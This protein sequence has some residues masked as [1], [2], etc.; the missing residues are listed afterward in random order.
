M[1]QEQ[2][3]A[4]DIT[5]KCSR[6]NLQEGTKN[7]P[8]V[9]LT[10]IL[11]FEPPESWTNLPSGRECLHPN[12]CFPGFRGR[13]RRFWCWT[14]AWMTPGCLESFLSFL[15]E[16]TCSCRTYWEQGGIE[17]DNETVQNN[18]VWQFS[19]RSSERSHSCL[20]SSLQVCNV[21][22]CK[23]NQMS[24]LEVEGQVCWI[25]PAFLAFVCSERCFILAFPAGCLTTVSSILA[26]VVLKNRAHG[27]QFWG[28]PHSQD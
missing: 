4:N 19:R 17:Q 10:P 9:L 14:S 5:S 20:G 25:L 28:D 11:V 18:L 23:A 24:A 16:R 6:E 26:F 13:D 8:E 7:Q 27:H 2:I 3:L 15:M 22:L 1:P 12:V 21:A